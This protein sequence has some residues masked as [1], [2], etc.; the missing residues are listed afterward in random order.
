MEVSAGQ[1][2]RGQGQGC[3]QGGEGAGGGVGVG[4][5]GVAGSAPITIPR[6]AAVG[7]G[8]LT[9]DLGSARGQRHNG[10]RLS[11]IATMAM[12]QNS[13]VS[14]PTSP[15]DDCELEYFHL[16]WRADQ[17]SG[18]APV[19]SPPHQ[20][21]A[22]PKTPCGCNDCST[23]DNGCGELVCMS[24]GVVCGRVHVHQ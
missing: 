9:G 24:C 7:R 12:V 2:E 16:M 19:G 4:V 8:G 18:N 11:S 14:P 22:G 15:P 3:G 21:P 5:A 1:A 17:S 13:F 10:V 23:I 6:T 20:P